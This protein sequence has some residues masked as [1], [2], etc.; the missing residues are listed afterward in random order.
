MSIA[1]EITRL[2]QAKSDL[3]T[4]IENKGV[5]VP[6]ATTIDGYAALVDQIQQG[7][8]PV[9]PYDA[10]IE[11][12][13]STGTQYIDTQIKY[14]SS[15]KYNISCDVVYVSGST[16]ST[17][18]GWDAGGA[19]GLYKNAC[20]DG[21]TTGII[22][23]GINKF[24]SLNLRINSETS[25]KTLTYII[26]GDSQYAVNRVHGSLP[27]YSGNGGYILFACYS[28]NSVSYHIKEKL[29]RVRIDVNNIVVRDYIPVRVGQVG[30]LYDKVSGTLFG[31][32]GTGNF[33]LGPDVT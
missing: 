21:S 22:S 32:S 23:N 7:S 2:Q 17:F 16:G 20:A 31:N 19:F 25:S 24:L 15:N 13:Q 1:S 10:V 30:Y 14:S 27:S 5:T 18:N 9:L 26:D 11:Y 6:S 33:I 8:T 29:Y 4:S 28:T 3:A 12:L